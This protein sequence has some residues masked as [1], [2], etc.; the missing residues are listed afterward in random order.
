MKPL[1]KFMTKKVKFPKKLRATLERIRQAADKI[2]PPGADDWPYMTCAM[3]LAK[4]WQVN[5]LIVRPD[6]KVLHTTYRFLDRRV[7]LGQR[8][9]VEAPW[10]K[11]ETAGQP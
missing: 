6:D 1:E 8:I 10:L 3:E 9:N 5:T 4:A 2:Q 11:C 7:R